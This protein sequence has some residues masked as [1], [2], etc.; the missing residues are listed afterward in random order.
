MRQLMDLKCAGALLALIACVGIGVAAPVPSLDLKLTARQDLP[1]AGT[2]FSVAGDFS[3]APD[4][5][6]ALGLG[7]EL[8][9]AIPAASFC[10]PKGTVAFTLL[11]SDPAPENRMRNRHVVTLR[12]AGRGFFGFYFCGTSRVLY[13]TYKDLTEGIAVASPGA[14]QVGKAYRLAATWDG[15]TVC[16]YLD[17]RL[18]GTLKQ[19]F[20]ATWPDYARIKL[21]P[22]QDGS[23]PVEPW[24]GND[25][26]VRD[27][28]VWKE[29]L[30]P[31]E[32]ATDAGVEAVTAESRFPTFLAV[33]QTAAPTLDGKLSDPAWQQAASFVSLLD[34]TTPAKS[35]RYPDNR[36]LLCHDGQN[37]YL[38]FETIFPTGARLVPGEKRGAVEPDVW[39]VESFELYLDAGGKM[40]RF[41]GNA[42][43]G[44]C[45]SLDNGAEWNGQWQ[46][47][48]TLE[49]RIDNRNHW[50]GEI[51]VPFATLGITD[52]VGQD[53]KVNFCR[54]WRCFDEVGITHLQAAT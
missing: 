39:P 42:A 12:L 44:Y 32:I 28:K 47:A 41:A 2:G 7:R 25:I 15:T 45:E 19:G 26:F 8:G 5:K 23:A 54:T 34:A 52:P 40:Y 6:P 18:V 9:P 1:A 29:P 37:L 27:L 22:Y 4:G 35:L 38:G 49:F 16:F 50:Q 46:Y 30:N 11:Y 31:M 43:G 24:G 10:G 36:P 14:L 33:P 17:G 48:S 51:K 3:P 20:A 13:M 53:L 21:G